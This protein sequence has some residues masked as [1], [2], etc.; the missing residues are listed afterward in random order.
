MPWNE[1]KDDKM[2]I[3]LTRSVGKVVRD[4]AIA[5]RRSFQDQL[6]LLVEEALTARGHFIN[7]N[8]DVNADATPQAAAQDLKPAG[9]IAANRRTVG[10]KGAA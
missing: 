9:P 2:H 5:D 7:G 3:R 6:A 1:K 10:K 4:L 8:L